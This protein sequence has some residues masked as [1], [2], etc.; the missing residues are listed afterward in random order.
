MSAH[1]SV[2]ESTISQA[3]K[4]K[5]DETLKV[6]AA[7]IDGQYAASPADLRVVTAEGANTLW[8]TQIH[9]SAASNQT[10]AQFLR[11]SGITYTTRGDIEVAS[12]NGDFGAF[13]GL[14]R[15]IEG[16]GVA[17]HWMN[18]TLVTDPYSGA[19]S[20]TVA[21]SLTTL[22]NFDLPRADNFANE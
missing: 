8:M 7:L 22:W 14:A 3:N 10:I 1:A 17:P 4:V 13:I 15:G 20:G 6:F 18:A 2:S 12:A 16:A 19:S 21:L 11:E 5:A 9:N